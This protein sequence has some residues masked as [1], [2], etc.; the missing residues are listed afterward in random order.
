MVEPFEEGT[1]TLWTQ[2]MAV[3]EEGWNF[4]NLEELILDIPFSAAQDI[5]TN[6]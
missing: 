4:I 3:Y 2:R 6:E 5:E 1:G